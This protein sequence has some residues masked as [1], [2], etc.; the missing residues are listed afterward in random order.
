MERYTCIELNVLKET[1]IEWI[2]AYDDI[3]N[4]KKL[5]VHLS[6][7]SKHI[8]ENIAEDNLAYYENLKDEELTKSKRALD[9]IPKPE[10]KK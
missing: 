6:F 2:A 10:F 1:F 5:N 9:L 8:V 4:D 3:K 7:Y